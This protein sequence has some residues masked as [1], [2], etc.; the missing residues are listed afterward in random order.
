MSGEDYTN[1][2][3]QINGRSADVRTIS[4]ASY[5]YLRK[6]SQRE[7]RDKIRAF[8]ADGFNATDIEILATS[9]VE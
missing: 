9:T 8:Y 1:R 5:G 3:Y 2:N 4:V 7:V 6:P